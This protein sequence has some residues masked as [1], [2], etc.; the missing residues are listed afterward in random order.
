MVKTQ[1]FE[2]VS[3]TL[4]GV[5]FCAVH[6]EGLGLRLDTKLKEYHHENMPHAGSEGPRL[7]VRSWVRVPGV[8]SALKTVS[9][10][11]CSVLRL[12]AEFGS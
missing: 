3:K 2:D 11:Y 8:A 5:C 10:P 1:T 6:P 7:V 12:P 4:W 9:V